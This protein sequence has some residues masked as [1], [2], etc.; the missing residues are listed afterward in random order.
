MERV[1]LVHWNPRRRRFKGS[2]GKYIPIR[3]AAPNNFGDLLGP[4]L[5]RE[6]LSRAG[7]DNT[8]PFNGSRLLSVGS[9]MGMARENDTIWGSGINGKYVDEVYSFR[10][11]DVRAVRGPLTRGGLRKRG[12]TVP[13]I[14]GDPGL[15]VGALWQRAEL[16]DADL[17]REVTIIPNLNEIGDYNGMEGYL[18]PRTDLR[19]CLEVIASSSFVASSSLHGVIIADALG[20]PVRIMRS[21]AEPEFKYRDYFEGTGRK[22]PTL[23]TDSKHALELG[24]H[25]A[26]NWDHNALMSAFPLDLWTGDR[27]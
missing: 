3:E 23:A 7:L 27:K 14:Y 26:L 11:V 9:I 5:V 13:E 25:D 16:F 22:L 4:F 1:E 19:R 21:K 15:L 2:I 10:R 17:A 24:P 20:V 18:D 8:G 12:Q 6:I